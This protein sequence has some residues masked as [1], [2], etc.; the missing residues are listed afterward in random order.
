[1]LV[2]TGKQSTE[3]KLNKVMIS[4]LH[5]WDQLFHFFFVFLYIR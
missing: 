1:M 2:T 5:L 3:E 4:T